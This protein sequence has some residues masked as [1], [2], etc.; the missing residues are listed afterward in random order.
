M[1]A[2]ANGFRLMEINEYFDENDR[3]SVPRILTLLLR[4]QP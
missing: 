3:T 2:K 1:A 4:K